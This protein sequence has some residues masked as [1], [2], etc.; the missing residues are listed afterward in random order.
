[1]RILLLVLLSLLAARPVL[2]A[3]D[4]AA[5]SAEAQLLEAV[6]VSGV[7]PGP[8]LWRVSKDEHVLWVLGTQSPLPKRFEW[9][10]R[11]VRE[12]IAASQG[13]LFGVSV[14]LKEEIGFFR[15]LTLLPAA[16][17][18][19]KD[20][21]RKKLAELVPPEDYQRW[22]ALKAKYLGRDRG[23]EKQRPI[24]AAGKLYEK[25]IKRTGL[26]FDPVVSG[27]VR[28]TAKKHDV[29]LIEPQ[30]RIDIGN[31]REA[32]RDFAENRLDDVECFR[33]TL[34]RLETDLDEMR[35][36]ANAW[37]M[38]DIAAL[39]DLPYEDQNRACT[40]A[41]LSAAVARDHGLDDLRERVR[42]AWL[43]AAE[44]AL[45][46]NASTLA[47]LPMAELLKTDGYLAALRERGYAVEEPL[48]M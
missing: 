27:L 7:Q 35:D 34:A 1:M 45:D 26:S 38:G 44:K 15:G 31:P 43:E 9:E 46:E 28:K 2:P 18:S 32:I 3:T 5:A 16:L 37:A 36:R 41:F 39:R 8:G 48:G 30:V 19:R 33:K 12:V 23:V 42:K 21:E 22:L 11:E 6:V 29:P 17:S 47:L 4:E 20:P 10:A 25:A 14:G 40:D 24:F 13:V